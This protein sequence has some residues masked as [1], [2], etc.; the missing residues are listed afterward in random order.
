MKT[1]RY[2][3]PMN[4]LRGKT[5]IC[6][7]LAGQLNPSDYRWVQFDDRTLVVGGVA[8]GYGWQLIKRRYLRGAE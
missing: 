6:R 2:I 8:M 3:G 4:Q 7:V 1:V 5:G